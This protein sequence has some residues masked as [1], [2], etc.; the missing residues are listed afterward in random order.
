M[1]YAPSVAVLTFLSLLLELASSAPMRGGPYIRR[2]G[3][4]LPKSQP[5]AVPLSPR[6]NHLLPRHVEVHELETRDLEIRDGLEARGK[7]YGLP[8]PT[9][10]AVLV[11]PVERPNPC[12]TGCTETWTK[13]K[14]RGL[15]VEEE[16]LARQ[17]RKRDVESG[18]FITNVQFLPE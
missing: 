12:G 17:V 3:L 1:K 18:G 10:F 4:P 13:I 14:P 11:D 9:R 2:T 6:N 5:H 7:S 8:D 15:S 16:D